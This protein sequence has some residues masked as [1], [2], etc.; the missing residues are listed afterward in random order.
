[1]S[2][3]EYESKQR[4]R[5]RSDWETSISNWDKVTK[6]LVVNLEDQHV[7]LLENVRGIWKAS[8]LSL[9]LVLMFFPC[10]QFKLYATKTELFHILEKLMFYE[11]HCCF[12][13]FLLKWHKMWLHHFNKMNEC[14]PNLFSIFATVSANCNK[15]KLYFV[16]LA[17]RMR[18]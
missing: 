10:C 7:T 14:S 9:S 17:D 3:L 6:L 18:A 1:M 2:Y 8:A 4:K 11:T 12:R 5:E 15:R 16:K 13:I